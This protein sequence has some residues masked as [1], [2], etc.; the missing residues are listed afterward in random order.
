MSS[1][2]G[3]E[4]IIKVDIRAPPSPPR[5]AQRDQGVQHCL[6][7]CDYQLVLESQPPSK[8]VNLLIAIADRNM[9]LRS[10]WGS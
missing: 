3:I 2:G 9:K 8:I 10:L 7:E 5:S 4:S 1:D 6:T